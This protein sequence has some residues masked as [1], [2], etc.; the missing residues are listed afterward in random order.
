MYPADCVYVGEG[1]ERHFGQLMQ[2]N[3][4]HNSS[5]VP[6]VHV[7]Q[8]PEESPG[9]SLSPGQQARAGGAGHCA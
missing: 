4:V 2:L 8:S 1:V 5:F 7:L 6:L 9:C 3:A